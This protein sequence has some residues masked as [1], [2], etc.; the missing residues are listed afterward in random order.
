MSNSLLHRILPLLQGFS[1]GSPLLAIGL[2]LVMITGNATY[3]YST[4][5][6]IKIVPKNKYQL[7]HNHT[8]LY[9]NDNENKQY[10]VPTSFWYWQWD[11][12]EIWNSLEVGKTYEVKVYGWRIPVMGLYPNIIGIKEK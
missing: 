9:I 3:A 1:E 11:A 7:Y 12:T 10:K 2:G 8:S 4:K 5:K 6:D